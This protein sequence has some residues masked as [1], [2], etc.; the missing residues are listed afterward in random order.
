MGEYINT[1]S[2]VFFLSGIYFNA[3]VPMFQQTGPWLQQIFCVNLTVYRESN[4]S[5][6]SRLSYDGGGAHRG[7]DYN[8]DIDDVSQV[9][10][11][12]Q[13]HNTRVYQ[14][15]FTATCFSSNCEPLSGLS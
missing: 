6:K 14:F 4:I 2:D 7:G 8:D 13:S 9:Y 1:G 10:V 12:N 11:L 3:L 5:L 15:L